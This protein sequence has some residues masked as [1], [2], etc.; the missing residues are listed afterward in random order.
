MK[1]YYEGTWVLSLL[2][3]IWCNKDS[4]EED[5]RAD[6]LPRL[7][8]TTDEEIK[9][10]EEKVQ[11]LAELA[12]AKTTQVLQVETSPFLAEEIIRLLKEVKL[13]EDRRKSQIVR[14]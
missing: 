4:R 10:S 3:Q 5:A 12:I 11:V 2:W 14:M 13:H 1:K 9:D 7:G 6:L 8:S